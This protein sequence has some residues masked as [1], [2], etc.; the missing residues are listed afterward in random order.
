M[1]GAG[2]SAARS[3]LRVAVIAMILMVPMMSIGPAAAE[4]CTSAAVARTGTAGPGELAVKAAPRKVSLANA[5]IAVQVANVGG[6]PVRSV[7]IAVDTPPGVRVI[8]EPSA[9]ARLVAGTS[10]LATITVLG[11]PGNSPAALVIRATGRSGAGETTA[12]TSVHLVPPEPDASLSLVGNT[13]LTDTSPADL[14]AVVGNLADVP[15]SVSVRAT[16]GQQVVRLARKGQDVTQSAPGA[17]LALTVPARRSA[18][19]LVQVEAHL[20]LRPGTAGLVV[21]AAVR[22][23]PSAESSDITVSQQLNVALSADVLPGLT[24]VGSV[25]AIPGLVGVWAILSVWY[26]DRRRLGLAVRGVGSQIWDNKLWLLAAAALSLLAALV[27]SAAGFADLLVAYTVR[28]IVIVTVATGLLGALASAVVVWLHRRKVPAI[29]P[30]ST[31]LSVL[32]A[33][34]SKDN[35]ELSRMVYHT[36][37]GRRGLLVHKDWGAIVLTPPVEANIDDIEAIGS[38]QDA[39]KEVQKAIKR[40]DGPK[41]KIRF[42][43]SGDNDYIERPC[44]VPEA[45]NGGREEILLYKDF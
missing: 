7:R 10:V 12:V 45:T 17:P 16:A 18:V 34:N 32:Q 13:R 33:A 1:W 14:M 43:Q 22:P 9:I 21:I 36:P 4:T 42:L 3:L 24:G 40:T 5:A 8:R 30:T 31:E 25:L 37:D 15:I 35:P 23:Y 20:P 11:S 19:V 39:I 27:Y 29:T 41:G 2:A 26:L 6:G 38:L 44:A 28:D